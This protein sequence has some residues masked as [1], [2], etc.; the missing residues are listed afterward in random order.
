VDRHTTTL[1]VLD[2]LRD[3]M[4]PRAQDYRTLDGL[5]AGRDSVP[6]YWKLVAIGATVMQLGG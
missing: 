6:W 4:R 1:N 2:R 5:Y 3:P